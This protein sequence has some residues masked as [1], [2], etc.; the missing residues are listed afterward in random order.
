MTVAQVKRIY[1]TNGKLA[2][3]S[4]G[5]TIRDYKACGTFHVTNASFQGGRLTGKLYI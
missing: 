5:F 1:G 4:G 3:S 2:M